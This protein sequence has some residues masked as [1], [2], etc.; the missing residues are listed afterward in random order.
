[1]PHESSYH[2]PPRQ[3]PRDDDGYL[4]VLTQAVFQA[5]FSWQVVRDKWPNFQ[6]AFDH[7]SIEKVARYDDRDLE[8]LLEDASI[9]RNG[10][11]IQATIDNARVM[12]NLIAK[13]GSIHAYLRS[14]D[15]LPYQ[16]RSK[17]LSKQFKWL[18]KT[19]VY[20]F[21]WCVEEEVP[22]WEER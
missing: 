17:A 16:E 4:A 18:G 5:G 21:L 7:F 22:A 9:V 20:F 14:M 10:K 2:V 12:R 8:R 15:G 1:M 13:H 3:K 6:R 19:G 11:K